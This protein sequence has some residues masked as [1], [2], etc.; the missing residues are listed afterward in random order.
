MS[1]QLLSVTVTVIV[2]M[3]EICLKVTLLLCHFFDPAL[4]LCPNNTFGSIS[5]LLLLLIAV[6]YFRNHYLHRPVILCSESC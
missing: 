2:S 4:L 3:K 6:G 5:L 1:L